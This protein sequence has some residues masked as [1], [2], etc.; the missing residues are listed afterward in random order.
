MNVHV[1]RARR[2]RF[3]DDLE[4]VFLLATARTRCRTACLTLAPLLL[5]G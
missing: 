2:A 3:D 1:D 4:I 5:R